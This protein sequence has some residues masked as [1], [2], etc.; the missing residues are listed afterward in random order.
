MD[1][2]NARQVMAEN[3]ETHLTCDSLRVSPEGV[4]ELGQGLEVC[5]NMA[6]GLALW[7][8]HEEFLKISI[9]PRQ[10]VRKTKFHQ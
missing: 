9:D 6:K 8:I 5:P 1:V 3:T 10:T 2:A 7:C 4:D